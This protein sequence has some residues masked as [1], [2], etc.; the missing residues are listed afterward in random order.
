MLPVV[1][2]R[3]CG[4]LAG[5]CVAPV[6]SGSSRPRRRLPLLFKRPPKQRVPFND[7]RVHSFRTRSLPLPISHTICQ[8]RRRLGFH[9]HGSNGGAYGSRPTFAKTNTKRHR[10]IISQQLFETSPFRPIKFSNSQSHS[11]SAPL[12]LSHTHQLAPTS[13]CWRLSIL[14]AGGASVQVEKP[15]H[16]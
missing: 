12:A 16:W 7:K 10:I 2:A 1:A 14:S 4:S 13:S 9:S 6:A 3:A 8:R 15:I 11:T 5:C